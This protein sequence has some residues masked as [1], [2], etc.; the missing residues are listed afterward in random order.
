MKTNARRVESSKAARESAAAGSGRGS[1]TP[2]LDGSPR[3][4]AQRQGIDAA[5]GQAS[6]P[7]H[8][9][10]VLQRAWDPVGAI[11]ELKR[12][13]KGKAIAT[14]VLPRVNL[15]KFDSCQFNNPE[16]KAAEP[17]NLGGLT[18]PSPYV[19]P[20]EV[21]VS[22]RLGGDAE[23]AAVIFHEAT[24]AF[25]DKTPP[26]ENTGEAVAQDLENEKNT[27][28]AELEY[29][30]RQGGAALEAEVVKGN[31]VKGDSGGWAVNLKQVE[32]SFEGSAERYK[33]VPRTERFKPEN[34]QWGGRQKID[35]P[36]EK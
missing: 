10:A 35:I 8:A 13:E 5:F 21:N 27:W 16:T 32:K 25:D 36:E 22:S 11:G 26:L 30:I 3:M 9:A 4:L 23:A 31:I 19:A 18:I 14:G 12:D 33:R 34:Y 29:R 2:A 6:P 24:H 7:S 1:D 17:R 28:I 20:P 15:Y